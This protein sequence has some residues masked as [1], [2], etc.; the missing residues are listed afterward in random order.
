[1]NQDG[2]QDSPPSYEAS[3]TTAAAAATCT[4]IPTPT[5]TTLTT[6][7]TSPLPPPPPLEPPPRYTQTSAETTI[8]TTNPKPKSK[9][10][11]HKHN[12]PKSTTTV[13][14][15]DPEKAALGSE[16]HQEGPG[17]DSGDSDVE[18]EEGTLHFL[19]H[20][21]DTISSLSLRY[22]IPAVLIRSANNI[23]S[24]HLLAGRRTVL[25][26]GRRVSLSPRP[27]EGEEEERRK[28]KIRRWM[29]ACK[30][31]DYDVA[32]FYLEQADYDF[33]HAIEAYFADEAW[34]RDHPLEND[35]EGGRRKP[36]GGLSLTRHYRALGNQGGSSSS[37]KSLFSRGPW[38]DSARYS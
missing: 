24:D 17:S 8:T 4:T 37:S 15:K 28:A 29:V 21:Q 9:S 23:G 31:S 35:G 13:T 10:T 14:T 6:I 30:V 5:P 20:A 32:V 34:E 38:V 22:N 11:H 19:N 18:G 25:I 36:I 7:A 12:R 26:P 16:S 1:M 3:I 2:N 33:D 27:I